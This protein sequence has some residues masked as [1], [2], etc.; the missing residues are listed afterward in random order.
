MVRRGTRYRSLRLQKRNFRFQG[1]PRTYSIL[2]PESGDGCGL[3]IPGIS[4]AT[5]YGVLVRKGLR[6]K[7]TR[8]TDN[9]IQVMMRSHSQVLANYQQV[10]RALVLGPCMLRHS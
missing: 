5:R 7:K 9:R 1:L 2:Q 4:Q 6:K 10:C 3:S 8:P